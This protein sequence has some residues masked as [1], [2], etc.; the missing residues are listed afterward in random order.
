MG[1]VPNPRT[2]DR[3]GAP[4]HQ[5]NKERDPETSWLRELYIIMLMRQA[6][7][8]LLSEEMR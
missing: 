1:E 2:G 7:R 8:D 3:V 5:D 6:A 4:Y